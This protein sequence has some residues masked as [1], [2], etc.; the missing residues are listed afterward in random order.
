[1]QLLKFYLIIIINKTGNSGYSA[2][3]KI[4]I[5]FDIWFLMLVYLIVG[6]LLYSSGLKLHSSLEFLQVK[7]SVQLV[8]FVVSTKCGLALP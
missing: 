4:F 6:E 8:R 1:M 5:L 7:S 3:D 2:L